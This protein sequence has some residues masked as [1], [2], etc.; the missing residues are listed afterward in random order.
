LEGKLFINLSAAAV[1][2]FIS[3]LNKIKIANQEFNKT[4][5][6]QKRSS[7]PGLLSPGLK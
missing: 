2:I 6:W 1:K 3:F 7:T 5:E 4:N